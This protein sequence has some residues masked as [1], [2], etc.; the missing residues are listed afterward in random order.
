MAIYKDFIL[1]TEVTPVVGGEAFVKVSSLLGS[2]SKVTMCNMLEDEV[3]DLEFAQA[4]EGSCLKLIFAPWK[5]T[6]LKVKKKFS[7]WIV[8]TYGQHF[9]LGQCCIAFMLMNAVCTKKGRKA[10]PP[11]HVELKPMTPAPWD[12]TEI[13]LNYTVQEVPHCR[14]NTI[15]LVCIWSKF[16]LLLQG[17]PA[18]I[19]F[20]SLEEHFIRNWLPRPYGTFLMLAVNVVK[21]NLKFQR[22]TAARLSLGNDV[23]F[24]ASLAGPVVLFCKQGCKD[25]RSASQTA[26][27]QSPKI[28]HVGSIFVIKLG[29]R[30]S[31]PASQAPKMWKNERMGMTAK[32]AINWP[33]SNSDG[34]IMLGSTRGCAQVAGG[35]SGCDA[36][37]LPASA[38]TPIPLGHPTS[39]LPPCPPAKSTSQ[40]D[41]DP[42][43]QLKSRSAGHLVQFGL[44]RACTAVHRGGLRAWKCSWPYCGGSSHGD[45]LV[46]SSAHVVFPSREE[47]IVPQGYLALRQQIPR[48]K[49]GAT[50]GGKKAME[51]NLMEDNLYTQSPKTREMRA[52][53]DSLRVSS[54]S[55][56]SQ[57]DP[58]QAVNGQVMQC[59]LAPVGGPTCGTQSL[60]CLCCHSAGKCSLEGGLE[61]YPD[62]LTLCYIAVLYYSVP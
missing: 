33:G 31:R 44:L 52:A 47:Q 19:R 53:I 20:K 26:L 8:V 59:M 7:A 57:Q 62:C 37:S 51:D 11:S 5:I 9:L 38:C 54:K 24:C 34:R 41:S 48:I 61:A 60:S 45:D 23:G 46:I 50:T 15:L 58:H 3:Y 2:V 29:K 22:R 28:R 4:D 27:P 55:T 30:K 43:E 35:R 25:G 6:T 39:T 32:I 49:A 13:T 16:G 56:L 42:S 36:T 40:H 17:S 14:G 10:A 1:K 18:W 12:C 21:G